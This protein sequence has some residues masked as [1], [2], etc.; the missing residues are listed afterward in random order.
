MPGEDNAWDPPKR[1][2]INNDIEVKSIRLSLAV[3]KTER[4]KTSASE[5]R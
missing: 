1:M 3:L 4:N 5:P 2:R